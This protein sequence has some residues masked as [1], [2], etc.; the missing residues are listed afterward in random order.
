MAAKDFKPSYL[1]L[2]CVLIRQFISEFFDQNPISLLGV[3]IGKDGIA[4]KLTDLGGNVLAHIEAVEKLRDSAMLKGELSLVNCLD[5]ARVCLEHVSGAG[6]REIL[7]L[8]ASLT[9]RDPSN[10]S[11]VIVLVLDG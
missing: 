9:S 5:L 2:T 1:E 8:T 6:S 4:Q 11:I 10:S 7:L 3:I